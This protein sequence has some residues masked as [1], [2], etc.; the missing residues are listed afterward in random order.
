MK[1]LSAVIA[2]VMFLPLLLCPLATADTITAL[3]T[4]INPEHLE[5][6]ASYARILGYNEESNTL[7]VELITPE[8]FSGEEVEAL[9]KGDSI[10]TGGQEVLIESIEYDDDWCSAVF[11]NDKKYFMCQKRDGRYTMMADEDNCVWTVIAVIE[12]P[13]RDSLLFLDYIDEETGKAMTLPVVHTAHE[14]MVRLL[15]EDTAE[16]YTMGLAANNVYVVFDEAGQLATIQRYYDRR[17]PFM[18]FLD[19]L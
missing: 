5:K 2:L 15:E 6:T 10:Y 19:D 13:V 9:K 7:T 18:F 8:C 3:A 17:I 4:E 14:L 11:F 1:K 16:A 12:C